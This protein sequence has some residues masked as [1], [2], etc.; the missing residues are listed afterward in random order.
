[1][2]S[3]KLSDPVACGGVF[4]VVTNLERAV[5]LVFSCGVWF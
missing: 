3:E 5:P 1:M 2:G 4:D